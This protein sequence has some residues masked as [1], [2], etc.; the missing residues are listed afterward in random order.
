MGP[1][2][3]F[4]LF[5]AGPF[6]RLRIHAYL[7]PIVVSMGITL[8]SCAPL[9]ATHPITQL[10]RESQH[11]TALA[12]RL[13]HR[14]DLRVS[15]VTQSDIRE[16]LIEGFND[17]GGCGVVE[18]T[19]VAL[20][21]R[22]SEQAAYRFLKEHRLSFENITK[23]GNFQGFITIDVQSFTER[24]WIRKLRGTN[25]FGAV[26]RR[27]VEC[28]GSGDCFVNSGEIFGSVVDRQE[29]QIIALRVLTN[30]VQHLTNQPEFQNCKVS[31]PVRIPQK[32]FTYAFSIIG[33][34]D[35]LLLHKRGYWERIEIEILFYDG[36]PALLAQD[37]STQN[38]ITVGIR[39]DIRRQFAVKSPASV[40][41]TLARFEKDSDPRLEDKT[42]IDDW[43]FLHKLGASLFP[44]DSFR[45]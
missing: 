38:Q 24:S 22:N 18:C 27:P 3:D 12:A 45:Q 2:G 35:R 44:F 11:E 34:S 17:G 5:I 32:P 8:T 4:S 9:S 13:I 26:G 29:R 10:E 31:T 36:G 21:R 42:G 40:E 25:L 28:G 20:L 19:V 23:D 7:T 1:R 16:Q 14:E 15:P 39:L 30:G 41:P 33:P 37:D 43:D 6:Q